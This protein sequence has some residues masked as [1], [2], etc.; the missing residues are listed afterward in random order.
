MKSSEFIAVFA[1]A[2]TV[3]VS[4]I[5]FIILEKI[6]GAKRDT[7]RSQL[8]GAYVLRKISGFLLLGMVPAGVAA[9]F[10]NITPARA[11]LIL[12]ETA[13]LWPWIAG[14]SVFF[15]ILNVFNSKNAGLRA[16][17]PELRLK[18]WDLA[19]LSVA[20]AG[21][22][23]YLTA[24]EYLF[25][26]ILLFSCLDA[27]GLWPAV[28]INLALYSALHLPKGLKE[29]IAAIPFGALICYLTMESQS[30]LPAIFIHSLQA[31][32][33]ELF[34]IYRNPDMHFN[35]IKKHRP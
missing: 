10:F 34:C 30:I 35:L 14:A 11:G 13:G 16:I 3:T 21:W 17:Y 31:V 18:E 27:F 28:T 4:F 2:A 15:V 25:R 29:A 1:I 6:K 24:Y 12:G 32:T 33:I 23:L 5:Y 20:V 8:I 19:G 26:G 9:V 7:S 22:I